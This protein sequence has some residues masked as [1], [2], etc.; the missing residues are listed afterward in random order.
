MQIGAV[1]LQRIEYVLEKPCSV[2]LVGAILACYL[3]RVTVAKSESNQ[4]QRYFHSS[5]LL[6]KKT[7]HSICQLKDVFDSGKKLQL[8]SRIC[9]APS[10]DRHEPILRLNSERS[11]QGRV[12]LLSPLSNSTLR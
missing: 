8:T 6:L 10:F 9:N 11:A 3:L 12:A 4:H 2:S 5:F 1:L 7:R